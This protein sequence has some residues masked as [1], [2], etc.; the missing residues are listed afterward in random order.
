MYCMYERKTNKVK[1]SGIRPP[2]LKNVVSDLGD[3]VGYGIG[4]GLSY[5]AAGLGLYT[6]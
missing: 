6:I 4:I 3:K 2:N 5:R 1:K